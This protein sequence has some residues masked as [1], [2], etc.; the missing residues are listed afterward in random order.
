MQILLNAGVEIN[1]EQ[2]SGHTALHLAFDTMPVPRMAIEVLLH[3]GAN[4]NR[5]SRECRAPVHKASLV[6]CCQ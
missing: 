1:L 3:A 4:V 6:G 5:V 2:Q